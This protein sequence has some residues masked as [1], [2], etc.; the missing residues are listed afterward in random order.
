VHTNTINKKTGKIKCLCTT[1]LS[2]ETVLILNWTVT[3]INERKVHQNKSNANQILTVF[4]WH[5]TLA[6]SILKKDT[7]LFL[8]MN[9]NNTDCKLHSY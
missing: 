1:Y 3:A 4:H 9:I 8:K 7:H 5:T 6:S 2:L